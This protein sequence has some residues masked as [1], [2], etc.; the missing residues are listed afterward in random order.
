MERLRVIGDQKRRRKRRFFDTTLL[1]R[2]RE[3]EME[4]KMRKISCGN[5]KD[6]MKFIPLARPLKA[7]VNGEARKFC[8]GLNGRVLITGVR[9]TKKTG[10]MLRITDLE[11][12]QP[13][14]IHVS[15]LELSDPNQLQQLE[16][17]AR[18]LPKL[19]V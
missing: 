18:K 19:H 11:G 4:N 5:G 16:N 13:C 3:K 9:D 12:N 15:R 2:D 8:P 17:V 6:R 10:L 7:S 14:R 1:L